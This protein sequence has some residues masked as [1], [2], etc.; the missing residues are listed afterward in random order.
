MLSI[1]NDVLKLTVSAN[2]RGL[3]I[4]DL[5]RQQK[6]CLDEESL[7]YS[8]E[9]SFDLL[10]MYPVSAQK[11]ENRISIVYLAGE[12][13]ILLDYILN[14]DCVETVLSHKMSDSIKAVTLP[15]SFFPEHGEPK[16]LL[17][18]M[19]GMYWD[20][21]G[22]SFEEKYHEAGHT[23]FSMHMFGMLG[24]CGGM[25]VEAE[26]YDDCLWWVGKGKRTWA[27]NLQ[28]CSLGV[29]RYDRTV[30]IY[31]TDNTIKEV[32]KTY[33]K[34]I[35]E[36]NRFKP[37]EEKI[38]ERPELSKLFGA[39]MCFIGYCKDDLDYAAEC[40]RLKDY[41]F[42]KALIYPVRFNT[43]S[44][45]FQMGGYPP[46]DLNKVEVEKIKSIGY[47]VAPWSWINEGLDDGSSEM[48]NRYRR[49]KD[50]QL[51]L[52][53]QIDGYKWYTCCTG[54][55]EEYQNMKNASEFS[56]MTWDHFDVITC[57]TNNECYALDHKSHL[58][59]PISK[60]EDRENIKKLLLAGQ[61]GSRAVSSESFND[62]Y[63]LEY[64]L[65][66]VKAWPQYQAWDYW[67]IPLTL[68]V[69]HDSMLHTWWEPHNYNSKYFSRNCVKY[70]YGGGK[71]HLMSAMDALYGCIPDVF[72]FGAQY[73]WTGN[74]SET[75][76]YKFRFDDPETQ[77]ALQLALP[78]A[79]LHEKTGMLEMTDFE[80]LSDDGYLQK[81]V[82]SD[83]TQIYANFG[84]NVSRYIE[85]I[86]AGIQPESWVALKENKIMEF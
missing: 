18:I 60:T 8:T 15:G 1:I 3:S 5:K 23:G 38:K 53:W 41:G 81:T 49:N 28:V 29:M 77:L 16:Y 62:S 85:A 80:F 61:A 86:G 64:D 69:Y 34:R 21:K 30:R 46:I 19:Q 70:Q 10:P 7:M 6:W 65:G 43:Y 32:A 2:G 59:R 27:A 54:F 76:L 51:K 14:K 17:P 79:K 66:S 56:D 44:K 55:M 68:L 11:S 78:V 37:W 20:G 73:G 9:A 83:G 24:V 75:M 47:D 58:G 40:Q 4:T 74:G 71:P 22:G 72:P 35:I 33:R 50:G 26:T 36:Q 42:D 63:T 52:G 48:L 31:V 25:L 57:V 12:E 45:D 13:R 67:P 39:V 82:F 84:P